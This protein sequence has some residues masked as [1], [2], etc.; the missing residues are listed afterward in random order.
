MESHG[1]QLF[2]TQSSNNDDGLFIMSSGREQTIRGCLL[3]RF[4]V[5]SKFSNEFY[6]NI[7]TREAKLTV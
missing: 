6:N 2:C 4:R 3:V 7:D 1:S 5:I